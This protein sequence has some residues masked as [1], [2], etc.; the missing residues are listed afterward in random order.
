MQT[1]RWTRRP[2]GSNWGEFGIDDQIGKLNLLTPDLRRRA[3]AEVREGL[4]FC[5]SLPLDYPGGNK[6][7]QWHY[8][9]TLGTWPRGSSI[10]Y[11]FC[12]EEENPLYT[13]VFSDDLVTLFTQYSTHWDGLA[14]VGQK[15]DVDGDG[16][17]EKAYYNG[18][19]ADLD[20]VGPENGAR[21]GARRLGVEQMAMA[22][23]QGR[24]VLVDLFA[25]FGSEP[26]L[27]GYDDLMRAM[28]ARSVEVEPGDMLCL[29]TG[30]AELVLKMN[31]NPNPVELTNACARL[32]GRDE[33]LLNWIDDSGIVVLT[34]DNLHVEAIPSRPAL[35]RPFP[36]F[37]LHVHCLFKLGIHLGGLW[38]LSELAKW[39]SAH[40]RSRFLLTAPPLRLPGAVGS[41]VTPIATV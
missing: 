27:V 16:I 28:A 3:V 6:L 22:G 36:S 2:E 9:P 1:Q 24:G 11:N 15:F 5:L 20:V 38:Y 39:L 14:H 30:F 37:P 34:A 10:D 4:V 7:S 32:D 40:K 12:L 18:Y 19:R 17:E 33:R 23:V 8:P 26:Q 41:P 35:D 21:M 25:A 29:H 13:D 31:R